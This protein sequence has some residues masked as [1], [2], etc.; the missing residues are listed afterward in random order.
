MAPNKIRFIY[1]ALGFDS[2]Y[3]IIVSQCRYS[4]KN[5]IGTPLRQWDTIMNYSQTFTFYHN[6]V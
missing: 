1:T 2:A 6:I 3:V 4:L 5:I